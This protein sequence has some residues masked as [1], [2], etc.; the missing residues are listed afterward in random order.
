[1]DWICVCLSVLCMIQ[2]N[3]VKN[4][5][6]DLLWVLDETSAVS[7]F[8]FKLLDR[9]NIP[10][11]PSVRIWV[12]PIHSLYKVDPSERVP[13]GASQEPKWILGAQKTVPL[14][15]S[16]SPT[17][18]EPAFSVT[19]GE[20]PERRAGLYPAT[21][22]ETGRSPVVTTSPPINILNHH[23]LYRSPPRYK[24]PLSPHESSSF[25][26]SGGSSSQR[27][28][29][30]SFSTSPENNGK[31][32]SDENFKIPVPLRRSVL[33]DPERSAIVPAAA[34]AASD[35]ENMKPD[36]PGLKGNIKPGS[37]EEEMTTSIITTTTITTTMQSP[38]QNLP[39]SPILTQ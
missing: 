22:Q 9:K 7:G 13:C 4:T 28:S 34:S 16:L 20:H 8:Y 11:N 29:Q 31:T 38:G 14:I 15:L 24:D 6:W 23:L 39:P 27:I 21:T 2:M 10:R 37:D 35:D 1:M 32:A 18:A 17:A 3:P 36:E 12:P 30:P 26:D 33:K 5:R 19:P 25:E